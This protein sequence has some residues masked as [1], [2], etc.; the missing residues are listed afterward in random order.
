MPEAQL[1]QVV[2]AGFGRVMTSEHP[3]WQSRDWATLQELVRDFGFVV[4]KGADLDETACEAVC[5]GLGE[6]VTYADGD[7]GYGYK[8]I[9]HLGRDGDEKRIIQG[10]DSMPLHSDGLLARRRVDIVLL[11]CADCRQAGGLDGATIVAD[12]KRGLE[13]VDRDVVDKLAEIGLDYRVGERDYFTTLPQEWYRIPAVVE[14]SGKRY[15]RVGLRYRPATPSAWEVQV[16]D[17]SQA[18]S[19]DII[20]HLEQAMTQKD[21][22]YQH[23]WEAGDL[24]LINNYTTLHGRNGFTNQRWLMNGQTIVPHWGS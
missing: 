20:N 24:L 4:V 2:S 16:P 11:Y 15:L 14:Q 17:V 13:Y 8:V 3:V 9:V 5:Y 19:D 22:L 10:R 6:P 7:F 1:E 21:V 18:E 12:Q 23:P